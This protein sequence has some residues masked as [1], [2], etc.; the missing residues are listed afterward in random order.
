MQRLFLII[1]GF[2]ITTCNSIEINQY[3]DQVKKIEHATK[4]IDADITTYIEIGL[5]PDFKAGYMPY[6]SSVIPIYFVH[7]IP[8]IYR[9]PAGK[10]YWWHNSSH[11]KVNKTKQNVLIALHRAD[12]FLK[13]NV[14]PYLEENK[15]KLRKKRYNRL[16]KV[17]QNLRYKINILYSELQNKH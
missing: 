2:G 6:I 15:Y 1:F 16:K 11:P 17:I 13:D 5:V 8:R 10:Y 7:D 12:R 3:W 4:Q 14:A 9:H